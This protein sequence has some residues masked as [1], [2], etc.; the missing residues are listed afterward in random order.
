M[1]IAD[2]AGDTA[3]HAALEEVAREMTA[4]QAEG[5]VVKKLAI[6]EVDR[7]GLE[8]DRRH[9][10]REE[11]DALAASIEARG[12]QT[13]IEVMASENGRFTLISGLRRLM[14]LDM[15]GEGEVLA[16]VRRPDSAADAYIAMVEENEIRSDLSYYE[17][18]AIA[19]EA[20]DAGVFPDAGQAV[21]ILFGNAP[22]AKRWKI[23]KFGTIHALLGNELKFPEALPEKFGL[24]LVERLESD[25]PFY[26][27]L[28]DRLRKTPARDAASE[29]AVLE[30]AL[31]EGKVAAPKPAKETL[32]P[33]LVIEAKTGRVVLSG[34][35]VDEGFLEA[36]RAFAVSHAKADAPSD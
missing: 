25:L 34:K 4:A 7:D 17:R 6:S 23:H 8:R 35:G 16:F 30:K 10:D 19:W 5:R 12:Q 3:G 29:R 28:K 27:R 26:R 15:L 20:T 13:P 24:A 18:A 2:V 1:P 11:L 21:A 9:I 31:R 33:G 22:A 14:A 36:L 32:A